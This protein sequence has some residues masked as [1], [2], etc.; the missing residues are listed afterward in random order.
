M[1]FFLVRAIAVLLVLGFIYFIFKGLLKPSEFIRCHRCEGKG[2]WYGT[3]G[4]EDC[5][6]CKGSGKLHRDEW[7]D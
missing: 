4:R 7:A 2:F 1:I 5:N 6:L 3:R